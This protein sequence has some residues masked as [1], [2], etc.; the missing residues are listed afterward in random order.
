MKRDYLVNRQF[1][2]DIYVKCILQMTFAEIADL[3]YEY[4]VIALGNLE[5]L[6]LSL[7]TSAGSATLRGDIYNPVWKA[8][9]AANGEIVPFPVLSEAVAS[10]GVTRTQLGEALFVLTGRG[11]LA[12]TTQSATPDEDVTAYLALNRELRQRSRY[13]AG[14]NTPPAPRIGAGVP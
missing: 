13:V 7:A 9:R 2:R 6:P 3:L 8:L 1:R 5:E 10:D 14:A 12:P 11:D 4:S